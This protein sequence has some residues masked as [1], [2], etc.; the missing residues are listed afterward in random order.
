MLSASAN[1]TNE[2]T[3]PE[4]PISETAYCLEP[5]RIEAEKSD[6]DVT[7]ETL[8]P[9]SLEEELQKSHEKY[10]R[11]L[12]DFANYRRRT[13]S[14]FV[15]AAQ[16]GKRELIV[17]LLEVA[18]NFELALRHISAANEAILVG[19]QAIY[20]QLI[21]VLEKHGVTPIESLGKSFDPE[22]HEAIA[23]VEDSRYGSGMVAEELR[24]GYRWGDLL[25]R[26][27]QVC[28]AK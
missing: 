20:R 6:G 14:E 3:V 25:L 12:A 10:L 19:V 26:P 9:G 15:Y 13:E 18:D 8:E 21:T 27:S 22:F 11:V 5:M 24:R 4:K 17:S 1:H 2:L 7:A 28:V 16:E 23:V